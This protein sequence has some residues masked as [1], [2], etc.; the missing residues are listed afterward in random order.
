[1]LKTAN[2]RFVVA[3]SAIGVATPAFAKAQDHS[4]WRQI[5]L[6]DVVSPSPVSDSSTF[7]PVRT[8]GGNF[9]YNVGI[10]DSY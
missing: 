7:D 2:F 4:D 3:L 5:N 10:N 1:M 9:G 6:Y 8:G